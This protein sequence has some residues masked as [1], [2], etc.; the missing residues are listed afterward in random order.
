MVLL[1]PAIRAV[2]EMS[3][4]SS[5]F[6]DGGGQLIIDGRD[7][8]N[9]GI[10]IYQ[11]MKLLGVS[12]SSVWRAVRDSRLPQPFYP[13]PRAARWVRAEIIR[14]RDALRMSPRQAMLAR[15]RKEQAEP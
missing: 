3:I 11:V 4:T 7:A 8:S 10:D 9:D 13:Q 12:E 5:G 6:G 2:P 1:A 14:A 15:S